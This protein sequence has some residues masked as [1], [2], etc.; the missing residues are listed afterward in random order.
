MVRSGLDPELLEN[1][2]AVPRVN[3]YWLSAHLGSAFVIYSVTFVTGM[4]ILSQ[5]RYLK[6]T[7]QLT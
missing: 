6:V 5:K 1:P 2:H 3:P 4:G 7:Y